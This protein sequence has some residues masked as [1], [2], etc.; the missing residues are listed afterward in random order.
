MWLYGYGLCKLWVWSV[1]LGVCGLHG[2]VGVV[3][4]INYVGV[5]YVACILHLRLFLLTT[6]HT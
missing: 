5:V 4:V 1:C 3:C 2:R 6:L